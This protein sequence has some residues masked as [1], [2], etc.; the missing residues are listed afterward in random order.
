MSA[1]SV[2]GT[3]FACC[4]VAGLLGLLLRRV[5]PDQHLDPDSK[6][7]VKLVMGLIATMAA[8]VLS[9]LI[10]SAKSSYDAQQKGPG[11]A[12]GRRYRARPRACDVRVRDAP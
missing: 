10:A 7:T 3:V 2:A 11:T 4:L 5:I 8:L 1:L 12:C 6:D 9:L